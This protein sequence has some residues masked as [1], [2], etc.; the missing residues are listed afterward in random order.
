[1]LHIPISEGQSLGV[2]KKSAILQL[3][4]GDIKDVIFLDDI[5]V[6][7]LWFSPGLSPLSF[8]DY[9]G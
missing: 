3:G 6:L 4:G 2:D 5:S 1:M 9:A 8:S 7:V